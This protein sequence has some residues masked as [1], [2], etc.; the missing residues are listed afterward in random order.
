MSSVPCH[1]SS[2]IFC[3]IFGGADLMRWRLRVGAVRTECDT[4]VRGISAYRLSRQEERQQIASLGENVNL[5]SLFRPMRRPKADTTSNSIF[6]IQ[7]FI[8]T[9]PAGYCGRNPSTCCKFALLHPRQS[10]SGRPVEHMVQLR[11]PRRRLR[12]YRVDEREQRLGW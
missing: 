8:R 1:R 2:S 11:P 7:Y 10:I 12:R 5:R 6:F 9:R 4:M 3:H